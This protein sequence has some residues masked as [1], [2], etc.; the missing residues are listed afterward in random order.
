MTTAPVDVRDYGGRYPGAFLAAIYR[1]LFAAIQSLDAV[2]GD[3]VRVGFG[4]LPGLVLVRHPDLVGDVLVG[5]NDRLTKARGLRLA[6]AVLGDGLLTSETP[7]HT[8]QRRLLLPAF[9]HQRL[10][11]Y[12]ATMVEAA[13]REQSSWRTGVR[14]D[15]A[16]AMSRL[17]L[18][19]AGRTLF[20]ADVLSQADA[21]GW[22]V[23]ET[24]TAF[25][26]S[27][28]PF[29]DKLLWIPT[30][31]QRRSRRARAV[32]DALVYRLIA[33][34]RAAAE[35]GDDL[36]GL[37]LTA[38]DADTGAR[39]SDAE[40]RDEVVTLL[41][42]GH[43]TTA[44]ALA[45]T[46][47]LLAAHPSAREAL[48]DE[49]D[50]LGET[51]AFDR[52]DA[53]PLTRAIVAESM[54]LYPPAWTVGREAATDLELGGVPLRRGTTVL[55]S[56]YGLHRDARWWDDPL[57]FRPERFLAPAAPVHKFA[58]VPFSAGR[59]GCIGERFAWTEA[60]LVLATLAQRWRLEATAPPPL[61]T[62]SVTLRPSGPIWMRPASR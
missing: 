56:P 59:R 61:P 51:P 5:L 28:Y 40:V 30:R 62:G 50:A 31:A 6:R 49:V 32:L 60:V 12:G 27:Q 8:R 25:D 54:R 20:S 9:H 2:G 10:R 19:I 47:T 7:H 4:R 14:L 37:L 22:A 36:L 48:H 52:L 16:E 26:R 33:E 17:T 43:E 39:M 58:Y 21:V 29:A 41:L 38:E 42:A 24:M 34:R 35:P 57:A 11:S 44:V 3:L 53:L 46:W 13:E 15:V 55:F 18:D 45:W 23:S 1:D